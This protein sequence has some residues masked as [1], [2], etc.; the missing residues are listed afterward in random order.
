MSNSSS[1]NQTRNQTPD[2]SESYL[3]YLASTPP[4]SATA[5]SKQSLPHQRAGRLPTHGNTCKCR[6]FSMIVALA[7]VG[8]L[9]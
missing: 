1:P 8:D 6:E 4:R 3:E 5:P 2:D 9:C 7:H